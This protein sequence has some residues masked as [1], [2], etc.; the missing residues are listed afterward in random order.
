[1]DN[2]SKN[3]FEALEEIMSNIDPNDYILY[4]IS[5]S[6]KYDMELVEEAAFQR[7]YEIG[8]EL[9]KLSFLT[10]AVL[11]MHTKGYTV[12]QISDILDITLKEVK[13][14][15]KKHGKIKEK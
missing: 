13:G 5:K 4:Q 10:R 1:M 15:I 2:N 6:K 9:S 12:P 11:N 7:G 14:L 8:L 3:N